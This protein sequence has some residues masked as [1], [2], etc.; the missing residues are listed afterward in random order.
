MDEYERW[1]HDSDGDDHQ[2][3]PVIW[4]MVLLCASPLIVLLI[5]RL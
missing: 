1:V 3:L 2:S 5:D 4:L